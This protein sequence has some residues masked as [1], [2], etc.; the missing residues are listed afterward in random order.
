VRV[1]VGYREHGTGVPGAVEGTPT[2]FARI[3]VPA[4]ALAGRRFRV[5]MP[6]SLPAGKR[7]LYRWVDSGLRCVS[8]RHPESVYLV[9]ASQRCARELL[10][11]AAE[12][13]AQVT[14]E[15][16]SRLATLAGE[17]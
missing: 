15:A 7:S 5:V 11:M 16:G 12:M 10:R 3:E 17:E 2:G 14:E 8:S 13:H 4:I 6:W 9:S 1:A